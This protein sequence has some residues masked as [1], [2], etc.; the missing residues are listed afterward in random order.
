MLDV[1]FAALAAALTLSAPAMADERAADKDLAGEKIAEELAALTVKTDGV[2]KEVSFKQGFDWSA[3]E[4]LHLAPV[5]FELDPEFFA[6]RWDQDS[7]DF[8]DAT[9]SETDREFLAERL[10]TRL[11]YKLDDLRPLTE[12]S[13][14]GALTLE[15]VITF[16]SRSR[17]G[18]DQLGRRPGLDFNSVGA[19][20]AAMRFNVRDAAG[21]LVA[22]IYYR[23]DTSFNDLQPRNTEWSDVT[24][25][26]GLAAGAV[27]KELKALGLEPRDD[28]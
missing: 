20:E 1:R 15:P 21:D 18:I 6:E 28:V 2:R 22:S 12:E 9:V 16:V 17:P 3:V 23:R 19:G 14:E 7:R 5:T 26:F 13:G 11:T 25:V 27:K 4:A 8:I 24:H 10:T